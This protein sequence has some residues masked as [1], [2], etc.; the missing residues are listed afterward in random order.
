MLL[1][2]A[3]LPRVRRPVSPHGQV[4]PQQDALPSPDRADDPRLRSKPARPVPASGGSQPGLRTPVREP[5][6][7]YHSQRSSMTWKRS[8]RQAGTIVALVGALVA[9]C[10]SST[11]TPSRT[12]TVPAAAATAPSAAT[13]TPTA[14]KTTSTRAKAGAASSTGESAPSGKTT[15]TTAKTTSTGTATRGTATSPQPA[16]IQR[17]VQSSTKACLQLL[18]RRSLPAR[19][20]TELEKLCERIG[21]R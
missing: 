17:P 15:P 21:R 5:D 16:Q 7:E 1:I 2:M 6:G 8:T 20:R 4:R 11:S 10:G 13:S 19:L 3:G 9:G 12:N 14:A 18:G